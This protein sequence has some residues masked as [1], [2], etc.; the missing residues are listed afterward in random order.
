[1]RIQQQ[2]SNSR[3]SQPSLPSPT[4][5]PCLDGPYS[6]PL[7]YGLGTS[8]RKILLFQT[9]K[10]PSADRLAQCGR[11]SWMSENSGNFVPVPY[12]LRK[13]SKPDFL[14]FKIAKYRSSFIASA[15]SRW[16]FK[17]WT[18]ISLLIAAILSN[19]RRSGWRIM[20][21]GHGKSV[22]QLCGFLRNQQI[23]KMLERPWAKINYL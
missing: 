11:K 9:T 2:N 1:M 12:L 8:G 23:S 21:G 3:E 13:L 6:I 16:I 10:L 15:F 17:T 7:V 14:A 20:F 19:S 5:R 18:P 4:R 22:E